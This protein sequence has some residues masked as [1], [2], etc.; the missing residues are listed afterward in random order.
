MINTVVDIGTNATSLV[1]QLA[2]QIGV[3]AEKIFPVYVQQAYLD[4][5]TVLVALGVS[6]AVFGVTFVFSVRRA[7]FDNGN[8]SALISIASGLAFCASIGLGF[9]AAP[10]AYTKVVNPQYHAVT[11]IARD[12]GKMRG[13]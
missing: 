8:M 5:L 10:N 4:G 3:A 6:L 9:S 12:I 13:Q 2:A 11:M 7:D 1:Q